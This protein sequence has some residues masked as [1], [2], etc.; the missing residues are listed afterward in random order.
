MNLKH[1]L[2]SALNPVDLPVV[3]MEAIDEADGVTKVEK[4]IEIYGTMRN[5]DDLDGATGWE[6]QEQ[7]GLY[8]PGCDDNAGSGN[9]RIRMSQRPTGEPK[10]VLTTKVK[11]SAG[12][13]ECEL[14]TSPDMFQLFKILASAGLRKKRY[15]FPIAGTE[16]E[17]EVDV[18][19]GPTGAPV[20]HVKI[21]LELRGTVPADFDLS[22]IT[23]PFEMTDIRIIRPG[24]KNDEDLAYVRQL[25]KT[26]YDL[27]NQCKN[28]A[29]LEEFPPP[30][31]SCGKC[32][33]G[34]GTC[35]AETEKRAAV[36]A[37]DLLKPTTTLRAHQDALVALSNSA[38]EIGSALSYND[39]RAEGDIKIVLSEVTTTISAGLARIN[40]D[41]GDHEYR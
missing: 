34:S 41:D 3:S 10:Y 40:K 16:M 4:E 28:V 5:M 31:C 29:S 24:H 9:V 13:L 6:I 18:F 37:A 35:P 20:P 22:T 23:L 19:T 32:G 26:Q 36:E 39:S 21:D 7:W 17:F 11:A 14:A 8:V 25:F 33:W 15:Y 2:I 27:P 12:N 38:S 1:A 30:G